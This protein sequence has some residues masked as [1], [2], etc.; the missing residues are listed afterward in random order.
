[1][2]TKLNLFLNRLKQTCQKNET[3]VR[4]PTEQTFK[5]LTSILNSMY[6]MGYLH[7]YIVH[8]TCIEIVLS[9]YQEKLNLTN[10]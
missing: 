10:I 5:G 1:M 6:T 7:G 4:V 8:D 3:I 9:S 2:L